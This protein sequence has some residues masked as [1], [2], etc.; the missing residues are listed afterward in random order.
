MLPGPDWFETAGVIPYFTRRDTDGNERYPR[1]HPKV[2]ERFEERTERA[3]AALA[4][5]LA[6]QG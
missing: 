6:A 2:I 1:D 3:E 5:Y 4:D